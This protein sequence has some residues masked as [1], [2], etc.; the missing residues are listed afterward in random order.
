MYIPLPKSWYGR[1][2]LLS[3]FYLCCIRMSFPASIPDWQAGAPANAAFF[4]LL[5]LRGFNQ[6][7]PKT[8]KA[9][10]IGAPTAQPTL[11][12]VI[13]ENQANVSRII[14]ESGI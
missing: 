7:L 4:F 14:W 13:D 3:A 11:V 6:E 5:P 10:G 1:V 8:Q 2:D 9:C 12:Y